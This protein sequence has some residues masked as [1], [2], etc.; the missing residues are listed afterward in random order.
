[1]AGKSVEKAVCR[2]DFSKEKHLK[3]G[4]SGS[5]GRENGVVIFHHTTEV[6]TLISHYDGNSRA[7]PEIWALH[8]H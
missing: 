2:D 8:N 5:S 3:Q 7:E 1:M 4:D 6:G